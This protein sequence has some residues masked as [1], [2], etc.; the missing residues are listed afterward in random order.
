MIILIGIVICVIVSL[1]TSFFFP[2][3]NPGNGTMST[4]YTISGIMFSIGMSLIVTS[5][6][7]GIKNTRIRNGIRKEINKVRNHFIACF[8]FVSILYLL[9]SVIKDKFCFIHIYGNFSFNN[10]HLLITLI[11]YSIIYFIFN[12]LAIQRLNY[13]IEEALEQK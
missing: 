13:Q 4:L 12:Y 3:F 6:V 2:D 1:I 9:Q 8:L 11:F 7:A 5:S 10:L